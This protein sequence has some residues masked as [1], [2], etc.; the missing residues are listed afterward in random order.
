[1]AGI[2]LPKYKIF[3]PDKKDCPVS[4]MFNSLYK[5]DTFQNEQIMP[6]ETGKGYCQRYVLSPSMEIFISDITF[7][8]NISMREK[9]YP[10]PHYGVAFCMEDPFQ[11]TMEGSAKEYE[12]GC[13]ESYIFNGIYGNSDCSYCAGQRFSGISLRYD[14]GVIKGVA[15]H[16]SK[17]YDFTEFG[18]DRGHF[19][20]K[21]FSPNI[22]LILNDMMHCRYSGDVKKI[23]LEGKALELIAVFM[24]EVI[25]ENGKYG[26]VP[27]LSSADIEALGN[28]RRILD[29]NIVSPPTIS[30]L[31]R[32]VYL[33]EYKLKAGF[34]ELFGMPIHAYIIDKRLELARV[35]ITEQRLGVAEAALLVGYSN[36]NYFTKKFKTKYG[37]K[38]SEYRKSFLSE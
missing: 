33:N 22:R 25:S 16:M 18:Y 6:G 30:E 27:A 20:T 4:D 12:I 26:A 23:Y 3:N 31:A 28:A 13:G 10:V 37:I 17:N 9:M 7:Y 19:F 5:T 11:W 15:G 35:L 2:V 29:G 36:T 32:L 34:R 1:M 8:K 38:P 21:K 24:D 14:P